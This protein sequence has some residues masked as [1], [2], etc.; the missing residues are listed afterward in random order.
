MTETSTPVALSATDTAEM[1]SELARE[2]TQWGRSFNCE[3]R[4]YILKS[5]C[6][7]G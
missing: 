6:D 5:V 4:D 1:I 7:Y 3:V 2:D